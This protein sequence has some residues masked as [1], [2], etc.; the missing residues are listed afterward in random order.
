MLGGLFVIASSKDQVFSFN[1]LFTP[2][3]I[4]GYFFCIIISL[5]YFYLIRRKKLR[6]C[7]WSNLLLIVLSYLAMPAHAV[8]YALTIG[9]DPSTYT[10]HVIF[11]PFTS[12]ALLLAIVGFTWIGIHTRKP[13]DHSK[14]IKKTRFKILKW[15]LFPVYYYIA[16]FASGMLMVTLLNGQLFVM[17]SVARFIN[18]LLRLPLYNA[19]TKEYISTNFSGPKGH[20]IFIANAVIW[21]V[22]IWGISRYKNKTIPTSG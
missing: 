20:I 16:L 2:S 3:V 19:A 11:I 21:G 17:G 12:E 1:G 14:K 13:L 15:I 4:F 7:W 5:T 18:V 6:P 8:L 9:P 22:F 10:K